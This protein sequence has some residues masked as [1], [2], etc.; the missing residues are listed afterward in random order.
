MNFKIAILI[1]TFLRDNLLYKTIQTIVDN[2]TNDCK[3]LIVDQGYS[4]SEKNITI[5]YYKTGVPIEYYQLSFDCGLA[6]ARN[7]LVQKAFEM[8]IPYCLISTDS[9]QF[10]EPYNFEPLFKDLDNNIIVNFE[11]KK[12]EPIPLKNIFLAKTNILINLWD[13][14]LKIKEYQLAFFECIKKGYKVEW[15]KDYHFKKVKSRSSE[16]YKS[17]C[18]RSKDYQKLSEQKLKEYNEK[19]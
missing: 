14:D 19:M 12:V 17:Y 9:I 13:E 10:T 7:F 3:I 18:K 1:T 2:Y 6:I 15:N 11:L 16:E 8:Q 4:S 5:N